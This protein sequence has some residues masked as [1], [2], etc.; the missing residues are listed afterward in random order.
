MIMRV[1]VQERDVTKDV[2]DARH[3]FRM[4]DDVMMAIEWTLCRD[5][6]VGIHK[7]GRFWVYGQAGFRIHRIPDT[8]VLYSFTDEQV[9]L[10]AIIF[11][12]AE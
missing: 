9:T 5:P 1:V 12:P 11:R 10:H 3:A 7:E 2:E 8:K 6:N 4:I